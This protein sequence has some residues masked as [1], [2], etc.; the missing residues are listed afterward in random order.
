MENMPL[1]SIVIPV[2]NGEKYMREAIDSALGQTYP[3]IEVIVVN[4]GSIDRTD[5]IAKSYGER[6]RYFK[7]ENGGVSTALNLA[8]EN[9][10]GEY[11]SWLSHDDAYFPEK[12]EANLTALRKENSLTRIVY[13]DWNMVDQHSEFITTASAKL[14]HRNADFEFG[15]F[16]I[17]RGVIHGCTLLIHKSHFER[18][19][20]FDENLRTTQ[21][22]ELWL[23]MFKDQ[24]LIYLS[25]PL[26][27]GRTHEK[28]TGNTSK[29]TLPEGEELWTRMFQ[30]LTNEELVV[31]GGSQ[32]HFWIY[33]APFMVNVTP[34]KEAGEYAYERLKDITNKMENGKVS[35]II[36]FYNRQDILPL[37][38]KSVQNQTYQNWELLLINDGSTE[39]LDDL[40]K[41]A[42]LDDRIKLL[43][44]TTNKGVSAARNTGLEHA[45]GTFLAF[46][47]S[48]DRWVPEKLEKQLKFMLENEYCVS[49]TAYRR[50]DV[51]GNEVANPYLKEM[52]QL[53][54]ESTDIFR[55]FMYSCGV[56]TPCVVADREF[57]GDVRF[58]ED[59]EYGEDICTWLE[60][61][62]K[63]K[64]G[65][66][67]EDLTD[68]YVVETSGY[69]DK[70]KQQLGCT[71]ILR[72]ILRHPHWRVYQH[73]IGILA[74]YVS[75][76]FAQQNTAVPTAEQENAHTQVA[77]DAPQIPMQATDLGYLERIV[78]GIKRYGVRR[79]W[80]IFCVRLKLRLKG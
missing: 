68:V 67:L 14:A 11:F 51:D 22:Y 41:I 24:R 4:D 71:E 76:L 60:L 55:H 12:I 1:V 10:R 13:S 53:Y 7:K 9:M 69:N 18:V 45:T 59:I 74:Q 29:K 48:D 54:I 5:E 37:C 6:I 78:R 17:V 39:S 75:G 79:A 36:P 66:M 42:D 80:S 19:G 16:P 30:S 63:G 40:R 34:Y 56:A 61:A 46:L 47:D 3:N 26:V 8:I 73:E 35:I 43:N 33:Q 23:K 38:I 25:T 50:I 49:H 77:P 70:H 31:I 15:L 52:F 65:T 64:W 57:W 44:H 20:A 21:D 28:Q 58:P 32:R 27:R 72:Y 62:W 2:Y